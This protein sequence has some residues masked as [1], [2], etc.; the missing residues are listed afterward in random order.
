[1]FG[2]QQNL[3]TDDFAPRERPS[4]VGVDGGAGGGWFDLE[5]WVGPDHPSRRTDIAKL[6]AILANSGD[7]SLE[8]T[9]G[10]TGYWGLALDKGI[11]AYQKRNG[12]AV[13]G[14]LRPRGPTI[15]HME[16]AFGAL[17]GGYAPPTAEDI[18]RHHDTLDTGAPDV[19]AWRKPGVDFANVSGMPEIDQEADASNARMVRAMLRTG[20]VEGYAPLMKKAIDEGGKRAF[21]EVAD[22]AKKLEEASPS[23]AG[24]FTGKLA[25]LMTS[26]QKETYGIKEKPAQPDGTVHVAMMPDDQVMNG[27]RHIVDGTGGGG[28]SA[29]IAAGAAGAAATI[30]AGRFLEEKLRQLPGRAPADSGATSLPG[31]ATEPIQT[32]NLLGGS[33]KVPKPEDSIETFPADSGPKPELA[34]PPALAPG[35]RKKIVGKFVDELKVVFNE[36]SYIDNRGLPKTVELNNVVAKACEKAIGESEFPE[37][38]KQL[39]GASEGGKKKEYVPERRLN[40]PG[41][42]RQSDYLMG[43]VDGN[44]KVEHGAAINTVTT[45]ADGSPIQ[46]EQAQLDDLIKSNVIRFVDWLA[47]VGDGNPQDSFDDAYRKCKEGVKALEDSIRADIAS[48]KRAMGK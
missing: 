36:G 48:G 16:D 14:V 22:L 29:G 11:R 43:T 21:A 30:A 4:G 19:I 10:P 6:E 38:I 28:G 15:R 40:T 12:L 35:E 1:M 42:D 25:A 20:D 32:P 45:R 33:I 2:R 34:P 44:G 37:L 5:D 26:E 39:G 17:L 9:Q 3:L 18:D 46:R 27:G 41:K 8:R 7:Y 47:K 24:K 31:P 13:D 23:A